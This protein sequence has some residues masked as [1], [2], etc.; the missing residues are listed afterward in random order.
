MKHTVLIGGVLLCILG[1]ALGLYV[2]VYWAFIGGIVQ[3]IEE[4]RGPVMNSMSVAIGIVRI[5]FA[6]FIG[7]VS[8]FCLILPGAAMINRA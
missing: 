1:A 5:L 7:V 3:V 8:S 6:G 2:G 4:I